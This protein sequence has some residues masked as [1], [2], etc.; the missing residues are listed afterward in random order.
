MFDESE[1]WQRKEGD[2]KRAAWFYWYR[3]TFVL[4]IDAVAFYRITELL[5]RIK[6]GNRQILYY[7]TFSVSYSGGGMCCK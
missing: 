6:Y 5:S 4:L 2:E 3:E 1:E 7:M